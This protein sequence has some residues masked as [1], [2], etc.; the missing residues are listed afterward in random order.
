M[1]HYHP[2]PGIDDEQTTFLVTMDSQLFSLSAIPTNLFINAKEIYQQLVYCYI[3]GA[4]IFHVCA[5][6]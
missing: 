1:S 2:L 3:C 6:E 5:G 4:R